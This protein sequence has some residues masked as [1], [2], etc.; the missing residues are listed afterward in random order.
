MQTV[1]NSNCIKIY[2]SYFW[3]VLNVIKK[4]LVTSNE[5]ECIGKI[6]LPIFTI[7]KFKFLF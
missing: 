2:F 5:Y 4:V 6:L 7:E 3:T 1:N